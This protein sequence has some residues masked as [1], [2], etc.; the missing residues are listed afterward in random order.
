M[1]GSS[2]EVG[3][4][5]VRPQGVSKVRVLF[6]AGPT[7]LT[8][9]ARKAFQL[10]HQEAHRLNHAAVGTEHLLLGLAKEGVSSAS[11]ILLRCGF[12]LPWLRWQVEFRHPR[13]PRATAL[14]AALPYT[15]ELE[16]F[17]EVVVGA[18]ESTE[19]VPVSPEMLLLA[20]IEKASGTA[21]DVLGIRP[22]RLWWLRRRLRALAAPGCPP[23]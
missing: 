17:L 13:G 6:Q 2:I 8:E 18:G 14:P 10:A 11:A 7:S 15:A 5:E 19:Q 23:I 4:A 22:V 20:L 3:L 16:E 12:G 21:A 1:R 9:R